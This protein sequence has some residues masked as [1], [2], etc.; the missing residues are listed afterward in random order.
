MF[1][2]THCHLS[3]EDYDNIDSVIKNNLEAG[4]KKI[5]VSACNKRTL[6]EALDLSSKYDC[7]YLT[8]GYH[9]EEAS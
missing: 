6:S 2:D 9:P 8:L 3:I 7:V 5:I 1:I 4:V